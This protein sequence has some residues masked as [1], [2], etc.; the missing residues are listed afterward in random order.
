LDA[1]FRTLLNYG[2]YC[3]IWPYVDVDRKV[4]YVSVG[5]ARPFRKPLCILLMSKDYGRSWDEI[6]DFYSVDKR[7][8]TTGQPFVTDEGVILVPVWNAGFYTHG[9]TWF[10]I[11]RSEDRGLSW[12][13]VY[14]DPQGTY[15]NHFFQNSVNGSIFIGV[16]VA[17]GGSKG[18]VRYA[19]LKSYLLGSTD[20][21]DTWGKVLEVDYPTALYSG[22]T[23]DD[24]T[25]LVAAR[26]KRTVFRSSNG[27][28]SWSEIPMGNKARSVSYIKKLGKA[29]LT[30]NGCIFISDDGLKWVRLNSPIKE[31]ALR[32]PMLYGEKIYMTG[33]GWRSY[34]I[35]TNLD[36]WYITFDVSK[37]SSNGFFLTR[38]AMMNDYV[39]LGDEVNGALL[40]L[41][42]SVHNKGS[43]TTSQ[44]VIFGVRYIIS[45]A[46]YGMKRFLKQ[47]MFP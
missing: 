26:E 35:S 40:R 27:G 6:A 45:I 14:E 36:K 41:K 10:A 3:R 39:F 20:L 2:K 24:Q 44:V 7:N 23:L 22:T 37:E 29:V 4:L 42:P 31:L 16:G 15:G 12:K 43:I 34:V 33:V 19:P 21:G 9:E 32:Y 8:T 18:K 11:Y 30:S 5:L 46:K 25:V 38:M 13:K 17:G 1:S 28:D 47:E